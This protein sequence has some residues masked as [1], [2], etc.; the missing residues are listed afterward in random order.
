[1]LKLSPIAFAVLTALVSLANAA[2]KPTTATSPAVTPLDD[3]TVIATRTER[4]LN[5]VPASVSV[6]KQKDFAQQQAVTVAEVLKKLPNVDFGGGPRFEG[7]LPTIRGYQGPAITLLVDGARSNSPSAAALW[8]PLYL[9]PYYLKQAE[10]IRG[11]SSSL[12]GAGGS[13]GVM[14]FTTLSAK[15]LLEP[16]QKAGADVKAGYASGDNS[17]RYNARVYGQHEQADLLLT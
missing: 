7:Q 2:D 8:S 10:V 14:S 1:M 15:D 12:Y 16:D 4:S 11:S 9:D 5:K 3:V 13:G 17:H 6:V